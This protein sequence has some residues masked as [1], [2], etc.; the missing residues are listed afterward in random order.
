MA[1]DLY[2]DR[3]LPGSSGF[4][5]QKFLRI[6]AVAKEDVKLSFFAT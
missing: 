5:Q 2:N 1:A 6:E 4:G 3:K